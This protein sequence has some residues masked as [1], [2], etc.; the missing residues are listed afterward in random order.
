MADY[1]EFSIGQGETFKLLTQ[2]RD[3]TN[4]P[5][6]ITDYTFNGQIRETHESDDISAAFDFDK[7]IPYVSGALYVHLSSSVTTTLDDRSYVYDIYCTTGSYT[8]RLLEGKFIV[9]PAVT[10]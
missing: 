1:T 4:T 7:I 3:G 5:L 9:R 6:D 10:R 8:R 2:L